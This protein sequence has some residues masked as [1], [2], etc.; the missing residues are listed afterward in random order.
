[1]LSFEIM[2]R[3]AGQIV[4]ALL[5]GAAPASLHIPEIKPTTLNVDWRQIRRWGID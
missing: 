4:N 5:D 1:M 3:Q 2:G